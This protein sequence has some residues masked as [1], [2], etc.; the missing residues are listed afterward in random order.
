MG[1]RNITAK[2]S[3]SGKAPMVSGKRISTGV[4]IKT[5]GTTVRLGAK[6]G[7]KVG[8]PYGKK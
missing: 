3:G 5:G 2:P 6:T 7:R 1:I 8:A 4:R